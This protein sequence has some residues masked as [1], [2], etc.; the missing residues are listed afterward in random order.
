MPIYEF[1]CKGCGW[2]EDV[3]LRVGER[4]TY[5]GLCPMRC[6]DLNWR[7]LMS[8]IAEPTH[9]KRQNEGY[10]HKSHI[11]EPV[12][13]NGILSGTKPVIF[14]SRKQQESYM[15]A[16]GYVYYDAPVDGGINGKAPQM[17]AHLKKWASH[18]TVRKYHGLKKEG[19]IPDHM[20]LTEQQVT[21]RFGELD[22]T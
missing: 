10:P 13:E 6:K 20:F 1:Q 4:R 21:E 17:P 11:R 2:I 7:R 19:K 14:A 22:A 16:N 18:P 8:P 15:D 3:L 5:D 12:Y 9:L